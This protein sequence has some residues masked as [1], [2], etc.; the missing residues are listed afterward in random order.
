MN[1]DIS[2]HFTEVELSQAASADVDNEEVASADAPDAQHVS[3]VSCGDV[4]TAQQK[5]GGCAKHQCGAQLL[6]VSC[7]HACGTLRGLLRGSWLL[8]GL[9]V[10][11]LSFWFVFE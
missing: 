1:A 4:V 7:M 6:H 5:L 8:E 10:F 11:F 3:C 2:S 9:M